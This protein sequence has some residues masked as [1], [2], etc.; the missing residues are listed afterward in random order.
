M[1]VQL[2]N[3]STWNQGVVFWLSAAE[4][5]VFIWKVLQ[6]RIATLSSSSF[7]LFFEIERDAY[8]KQEGQYF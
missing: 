8:K 6:E 2:I 5:I 1:S 4:L 3:M 7:S